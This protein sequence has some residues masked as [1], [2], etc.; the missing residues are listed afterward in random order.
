ML[1]SGILCEMHEQMR[2]EKKKSIIGNIERIKFFS[3]LCVLIYNKI[4]QI[5]KQSKK[6]EE[7]KM[8]ETLEE[9]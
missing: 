8:N 6:Y 9:K 1:V 7:F 2:E 4:I 3:K 5:K